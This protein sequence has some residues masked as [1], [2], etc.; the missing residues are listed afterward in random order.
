MRILLKLLLHTISPRRSLLCAGVARSGRISWSSTENP[1]SAN[2][3]A[4]S[5]PASLLARV[6]CPVLFAWGED[7]PLGGADVARSFVPLVAGAE[8][9]L[10]AD[11]GHAPWMEHP[12]RG[13]IS[14]GG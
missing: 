5:L 1:R 4:D 7:D 9:E 12:E 10:W 3:K 2:C 8:L 14:P 6:R 11:T 13:L